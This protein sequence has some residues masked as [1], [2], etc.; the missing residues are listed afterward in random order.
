MP[1]Q[2]KENEKESKTV[3]RIIQ[4]ILI[5]IIILLLLK[6]CSLMKKAGNDDNGR[7]FLNNVGTATVK[8]MNTHVEDLVNTGTL[9]LNNTPPLI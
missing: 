6:N 9:T 2:E 5:I 8:N 7:Y 3:D 1:K 4:I